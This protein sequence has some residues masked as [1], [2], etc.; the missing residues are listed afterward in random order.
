MD[1]LGELRRDITNF[2]ATSGYATG[3]TIKFLDRRLCQTGDVMIRHGIE[4]E[5]RLDVERLV[6]ESREW[7]LPI[8]RAVVEGNTARLWIQ[9]ATAF[10]WGLE[11]YRQRPLIGVGRERIFIRDEAPPDDQQRD[12]NGQSD[13]LTLTTFRANALRKVL[14]KC[15]AFTGY[16]LVSEQEANGDQGSRELI[17]ITIVHKKTRGG[18]E[19]QNGG[20][21]IEMLCGPVLHGTDLATAEEYIAR[22]SNDMQ[23]IAQHKYRVDLRHMPDS[24]SSIASLGRSAAI[25]D[26]LQ[27][28]HSSAIDMRRGLA[29]S[30]I[31]SSKG[32]S[33]ILYNYARLAALF[34]KYET[35]RQTQGYPELPSTVEGLDFTLLTEPDEWQLLFVYVIGFPTALRQTLGDGALERMVPH[36]LLEFA[37]GLVSCLSKYYRQTRILTENRPKLV[38]VM[39]VRLCMLRS[40]Y[41]TLNVLL[42][43]L[44]LEAV[45]KM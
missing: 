25:V 20:R 3:Y 30:T 14:R 44:D 45:T 7:N 27:A 8:E 18:S 33:F 31:S 9:R 32:A 2:L 37:F 23:L 1:L 5:L 13:A 4:S 16:Q 39:V 28:K 26:L 6:R 24:H 41:H 36:R 21:N 15:F 42:N 43:L 38:P 29:S 17:E 19:Q 35:M 22:R 12:T 11:S 40:V 10:R 34:E